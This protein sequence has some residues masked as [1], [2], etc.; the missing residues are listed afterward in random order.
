WADAVTVAQADF[1][2]LEGSYE[3][4]VVV[5]NPPYGVRVG[6]DRRETPAPGSADA[7][8]EAALTASLHKLYADFGYF[9]KTRCP[10]ARACIL[11]PE[12]SYE[13]DIWFKPVRGLFLDNGALPVRANVYEVK[14]A[15]S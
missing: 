10:G 6:P 5:V 11:F 14:G 3:G 4:A 9:L 8:A 2:K 13:K 12:P 1:R 7:A 15:D